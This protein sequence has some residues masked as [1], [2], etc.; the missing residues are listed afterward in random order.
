MTED[1]KLDAAVLHKI[2]R[3][4]GQPAPF[5][6]AKA[7]AEVER[8]KREHEHAIWHRHDLIREARKLGVSWVALSRWTGLD[9]RSLDRIVNER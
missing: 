5:E 6:F 9:V 7:N 2:A 4:P 8:T 3:Q 1:L